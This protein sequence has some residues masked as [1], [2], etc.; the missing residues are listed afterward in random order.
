VPAASLRDRVVAI[1]VIE[2]DGGEQSVLP[3]T[4]AVL[5]LQVHGRVRGRDGLLSTAGVTGIQGA[6]RRYGYLGPTTSV[7]V[8]FTPQGAS[9]LGVPASELADRSVGLDVLLSPA[10]AREVSERLCEASDAATRVQVVEALLLE[11]AWAPDMLIEA[12]LRM[13]DEGPR[14]RSIVAAVARRLEISER[15]LERRFLARVGVT[16]R[17]Y[18]SLRRFEQAV[19]LARVSPSLTEAALAAGYYDQSHFIRDVRRFAGATPGA[20]FGR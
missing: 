12:A 2:Q 5:G 8:R 13:L 16:P 19:A 6:A 3:S 20:L 1:D 10:R 14:E 15:Q 7:L 11:L 17:A 9:C 4:S 18:A